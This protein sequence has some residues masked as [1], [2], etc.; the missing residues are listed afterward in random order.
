[1]L[2]DCAKRR[3]SDQ[4]AFNLVN[5]SLIV[6][7]RG[8][9]AA[10]R[11]LGVRVLELASKEES[12]SQLD[13]RVSQFE[14]RADTV[15]G[16][17]RGCSGCLQLVLLPCSRAAAVVPSGKQQFKLKGTKQVLGMVGTDCWHGLE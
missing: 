16:A 17:F 12:L 13:C 3:Q 14:S 6:L 10:N 15:P 11:Q 5:C 9:Q 1:M 7:R 8:G 2:S 4:V